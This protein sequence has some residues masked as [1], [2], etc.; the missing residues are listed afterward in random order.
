[1]VGGGVRISEAQDTA[2]STLRLQPVLGGLTDPLYVTSAHDGS[3][4][5]FVVEQVGRIKVLGPG[6]T[7]PTVFLDIVS[8]VLSGGERGLLG[9]AFHPRYATNGRFF[10]NYTRRTDG[11]T[12][13][14]EYHVSSSDP[15]VASRVEKVI[16]TV[17]QPFSN[18]NGGMIEFGSD[19]FLYIGL[20]DGGSANDPDDRAQDRNDL[21]G[22]LLRIDV[23]T[24]S[25]ATPYSSPSS[26]PF[27]GS[28]VGRDEIYAL[29]FRNPWRFSFDRATGDLLAGDVGQDAWEE[30]D[31]VTRG[32]NYGWRV[33]EGNHCTN[34]DPCDTSG[35]TF[36]IA[37]YAHSVGRCSVTGGY[38]Y[39]GSR[40]T[41]PAG[42]YVFGDF[43]TGEIFALSGGGPTLLMNTSRLLPSFGE[44]EAG[45]IYVVDLGGAVDRLVNTASGSIAASPNPVK[46]C[47][48]SGLGVTNVS[49]SARGVSIV[50]VRLGSP[51]GTLFARTGPEGSKTTG[52]WVRNGTKFFLQNV[53]GGMALDSL[54]T[55][56]TVTI[57]VTSNGCPTRSG[58]ISA[59]P[60]PIPVCDG[61]GLGVTNV[62]WSSVG[63]TVVEVHL[64]SPSGTLFAR[65]GPSG[66]K[67]TG[68]WVRDGTSFLL[69]DVSGGRPLTTQNTIAATTV[70]L[71]TAGCP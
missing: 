58:T 36:P 71:S 47:D 57:A 22:K 5:L 61:S 46:A 4:R 37:E 10:V 12:V 63:T 34:I 1:M 54:H 13:I 28:A 30:I 35:L 48:G 59:S 9:L 68:K 27:F 14:A 17:A 69:Q 49:W 32:G 18:H 2:P 70:S 64:G 41:L 67:R 43:C 3:R 6:E 23:D 38:A 25:G 26:N 50:E 60:N 24:P 53:T 55:L 20:G 7:S 19:G 52:K 42:T 45:E 39:R 65:S 51:T 31:V 62:A 16:L 33:F 15:D 66:D 8:R 21:L 56:A 40:S 44:D 11:A 29:G